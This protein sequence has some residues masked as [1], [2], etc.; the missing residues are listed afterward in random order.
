MA[1]TENSSGVSLASLAKASLDSIGILA[2][3]A[4]IS[5]KLKAMNI[6]LFVFVLAVAG[7]FFYAATQLSPNAVVYG[8]DF[9][10]F[11]I[12]ALIV[13]LGY[14]IVLEIV[15]KI[16]SASIGG[17][18][19]SIIIE[20]IA[21]SSVLA[22][23]LLGLPSLLKLAVLLLAVQL[24]AIFV[25]GPLLPAKSGD[26]EVEKNDLW[27]LLGRISTII[28]ILSFLFDIALFVIKFVL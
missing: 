2:G 19:M 4:K 5:E 22:G 24:G 25:G 16:A 6:M 11:F 26:V 3:S 12:F 18:R 20:F 17:L 14:G 27:V 28:T 1:E 9:L 23:A 8:V 15:S 13:A 21:V 7:T 10:V